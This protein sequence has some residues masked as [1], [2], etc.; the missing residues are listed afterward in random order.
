MA[1]HVRA[2]CIAAVASL[3]VAASSAHSALINGSFETPIVP[4]DPG[5]TIFPVGSAA[6]TGWTVFGPPGTNVAIVS[7]SFAQNGVSFTAQNGIQ[8][9][10]LTGLSNST[11]GVSQA[12]ATALGHKYQLS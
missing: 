12:V 11:E 5:Y 10:D 9:L 2:V 7:G 1:K 6:L 8:W 4:S 3:F